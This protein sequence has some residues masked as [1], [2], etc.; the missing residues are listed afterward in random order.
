M[1]SVINRLLYLTDLKHLKQAQRECEGET[2]TKMSIQS[3]AS[4]KRAKQRQ[5]HAREGHT[6]EDSR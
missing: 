5:Q 6:D 2:V 4:T 3:Q 1:A